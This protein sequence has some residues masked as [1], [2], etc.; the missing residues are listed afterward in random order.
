MAQRTP[1]TAGARQPRAAAKSRKPSASAS[2][3]VVEEAPGLGIDA[4][5]AVMTTVVL[6]AALVLIDMMQGVNGDG[7]FF[8]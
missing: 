1:R 4:G 8:N 7:I 5:I 2:V 6:V 3:E